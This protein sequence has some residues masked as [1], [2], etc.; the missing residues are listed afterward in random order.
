VIVLGGELMGESVVWEIDDEINA[1]G[2]ENA[3]FPL[4]IHEEL[5]MKEAEHVEGFTPEVAWVTEAGKHGKLDQRL[6]I[7]PTSETIIG[8][9]MRRYIHSHRDLPQLINQWCNV[10]RAAM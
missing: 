1:I 6:A 4:L 2:H 10:L 5:F 8:T 7:R 9:V 3:Y